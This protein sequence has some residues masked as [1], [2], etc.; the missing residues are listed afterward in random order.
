MVQQPFQL[1]FLL[2]DGVSFSPFGQKRT[3][4]QSRYVVCVYHLADSRSRRFIVKQ[5]IGCSDVALVASHHVA[6]VVVFDGWHL[7]QGE[8]EDENTATPTAATAAA[9][10]AAT[11]AANPPSHAAAAAA[12]G[13]PTSLDTE[14]EYRGPF[15][16][17]GQRRGP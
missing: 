3:R 4:S 5:Y 16:A 6:S 10:A 11:S 9:A 2:R 14:R 17:A 12:A 15:L 1:Q 7:V 8:G 13:R